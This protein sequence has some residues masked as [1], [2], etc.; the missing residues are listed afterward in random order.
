[1]F[2]VL[3]GMAPDYLKT[4][5]HV[6]NNSS[7]PVR[8]NNLKINLPQPKTNFLKKSFACHGAASWNKLLSDL[9][10]EVEESQSVNSFRRILN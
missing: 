7:Y 5:F 8:N 4:L 10:R 1:M 2:K 9:I 3:K 6:C